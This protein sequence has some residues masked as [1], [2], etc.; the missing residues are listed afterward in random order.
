MFI[1]RAQELSRLRK[2]FSLARPSLAFGMN[3]LLI[4]FG[5]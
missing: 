1:G 5:R 2:E 4:G 3:T